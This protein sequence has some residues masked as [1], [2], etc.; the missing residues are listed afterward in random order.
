MCEVCEL[1]GFDPTRENN[2]SF[3]VWLCHKL[4][5]HLKSHPV[6]DENAAIDNSFV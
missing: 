6:P 2:G 1:I 4:E 5:E 3:A